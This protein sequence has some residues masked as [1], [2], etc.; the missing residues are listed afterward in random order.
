MSTSEHLTMDALA[1]YF[2]ETLDD[3]Q[4]ERV[5]LHL[6][7]CDRCAA[8][9]RRVHALSR[10]VEP[11]LESWTAASHAD[12]DLRSMTVAGLQGA[13]TPSDLT[14]RVDRLRERLKSGTLNLIRQASGRLDEAAK[15]AVSVL[16][17]P[18]G[19]EMSARPP[20][21]ATDPVTT[22]QGED[23]GPRFQTEIGPTLRVLPKGIGIEVRVE[24]VVENPGLV[25]LIPTGERGRSVIKALKP[26]R[27][28]ERT[29]FARFEK[30]DEDF[31][32]VLEPTSDDYGNRH[33]RSK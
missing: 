30:K 10:D 8:L 29:F 11:A 24:G 17:P 12:A 22:F 15:E 3:E 6:A 31:V 19:W 25:A 26:A 14:E 13:D 21:W 9:A 4:E 1:A 18:P 20:A 16:L 32:V 28:A 7:D 2:A 23:D 5:D 33:P 27:D